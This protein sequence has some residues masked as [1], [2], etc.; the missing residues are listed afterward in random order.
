LPLLDQIGQAVGGQGVCL[1]VGQVEQLAGFVAQGVVDGFQG[2]EDGIGTAVGHVQPGELA[3]FQQ[4]KAGVVG[5]THRL[6]APD[7]D[8][9]VLADA[10]KRPYPANPR[11]RPHP[12][13]PNF[14]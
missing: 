10:G 5:I 3:A 7:G 12:R 13:R 6:A 1:A 8:F 2:E 9:I 4:Q 11:N 14:L